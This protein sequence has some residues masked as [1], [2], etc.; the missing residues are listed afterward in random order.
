[1][2][3]GG[4]IVIQ[5]EIREA[6]DLGQDTVLVLIQRGDTITIRKERDVLACLLELSG[7]RLDKAW[8]AEDEVWDKHYEGDS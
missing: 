8:G 5:E 4:G 7:S 2:D 6:L 3:E 1:M